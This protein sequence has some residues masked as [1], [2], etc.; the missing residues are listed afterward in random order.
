MFKTVEHLEMASSR[1]RLN[2]SSHT[3]DSHW[4]E[5]TGARR[6]GLPLLRWR[7]GMRRRRGDGDE[8]RVRSGGHGRSVHDDDQYQGQVCVCV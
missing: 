6:D 5:P 2:R 3:M 8:V 7:R 1:M 4:H